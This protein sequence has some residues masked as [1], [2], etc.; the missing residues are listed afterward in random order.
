[1][2]YLLYNRLLS[3]K[4]LILCI[5]GVVVVVTCFVMSDQPV[6]ESST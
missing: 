5:S 2:K 1:M 4:N 6:A 3:N